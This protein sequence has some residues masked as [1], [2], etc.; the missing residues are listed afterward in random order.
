MAWKTNVNQKLGLCVW[1]VMWHKT[2][3]SVCDWSDTLYIFERTE[4]RSSSSSWVSGRGGLHQSV[5]IFYLQC[6]SPAGITHL[7][8]WFTCVVSFLEGV[9]LIRLFV[10]GLQTP[11]WWRRPRRTPKAEGA[12]HRA[13][14]HGVRRQPALQHSARRHRCHLQ[15][16][17]PPERS[18]SARQRNRQVQRWADLR[19]IT[20]GYCLL[21]IHTGFSHKY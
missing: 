7:D 12:S 17:Q 6:L 20:E 19:M 11:R 9:E 4:R 1:D 2:I 10:F 13:A 8:Q 3:R 14:L 21:I 15:R 5:C 16:P 18:T